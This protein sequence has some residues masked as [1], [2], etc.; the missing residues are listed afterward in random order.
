MLKHEELYNSLTNMMEGKYEPLTLQYKNDLIGVKLLGDG[1]AEVLG[2]YDQNS[3][4]LKPT[5]A[6]DRSSIEK[7]LLSV[8]ASKHDG[9]TH[10]EK[11]I[12]LD[13]L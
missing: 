4:T 7:I 1:R 11:T 8:G 2:S 5:P 6:K 9:V 3:R 13:D 12:K 10:N